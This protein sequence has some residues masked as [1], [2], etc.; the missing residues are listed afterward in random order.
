MINLEE[1]K[2]YLLVGRQNSSY[3]DGI[4]LYDQFLICMTQLKKFTFNIKSRIYN[5]HVTVELPSNEDIQY[6]FNRRIYSKVVSYVNPEP[7]SGDGECH[8]YSIPY[9]FEYFVDLKNS[10]QGG[11]FHKVRQL[12]MRD[13]IPFEHNLFKLIS[14]DFPYLEILYVSNRYP[15]KDKQNSSILITFPY[16]KSLNIQMTHVDYAELFLMKKNMY[17]PRLIK[18]FISYESL[19]TITKNFTNDATFFNFSELRSIV[20]DECTLSE[21]FRQ[22]APLLL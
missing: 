9:D 3:I 1:L 8:I 12:K 19:T 20:C 13:K 14:K 6:S 5:N 17:L 15:Q 16:L 4:Q 7:S 22:Y 18:L 11:I 10:F 21:N 2:L